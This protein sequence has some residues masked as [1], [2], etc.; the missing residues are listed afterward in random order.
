MLIN[1]NEEIDLLEE[2]QLELEED[3]ERWLT[4]NEP[5]MESATPI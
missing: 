2:W 4:R 3:G 5:Y 1:H